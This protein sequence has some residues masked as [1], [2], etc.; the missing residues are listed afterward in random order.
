MRRFYYLI[1]LLPIFAGCNPE[2]P[3]SGLRLDST[4]PENVRPPTS[5]LQVGQ[6]APPL[7]DDLPVRLGRGLLGPEVDQPARSLE[8]ADADGKPLK[9]SDYRGKV[10]VVSFWATSCKGCV[11]MIPHE[12]ELVKRMQGRPFVLLGVNND[13]TPQD[14][15]GFVEKEHINWPNIY[16]GNSG[17]LTRAWFVGG[18]PTV[19]VID[20]NGV[21]RYAN[22]DGPHLN[23]VVDKLVKEAES[24]K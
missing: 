14:L 9:L 23:A 19:D 22:V 4:I 17:P 18:F 1:L 7:E 21:Y 16:D 3:P 12:K 2:H 8:G 13:D 20:A 15:K 6:P 11:E 5:G 24:G 10:V